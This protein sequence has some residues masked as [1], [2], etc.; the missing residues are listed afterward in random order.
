M[1]H[2]RWGGISEISAPSFDLSLLDSVTGIGYRIAPR[3]SEAM[4]R[5]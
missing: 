5:G 2:F 3:H 4:I 1:L